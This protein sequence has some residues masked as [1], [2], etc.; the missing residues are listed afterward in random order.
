[1]KEEHRGVAGF[2]DTQ[3]FVEGECRQ[4]AIGSKR[5]SSKN[6]ALL[7]LLCLEH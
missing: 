5:Q 3:Q 6:T 7:C 2:I 4:K 1:M